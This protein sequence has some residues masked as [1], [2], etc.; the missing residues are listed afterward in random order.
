[1]ASQAFVVLMKT[2]R[3]WLVATNILPVGV[4]PGTAVTAMLH[5]TPLQIQDATASQAFVVLTKTVRCW[6]AAT[7]ILPVGVTAVTA[8]GTVTA[9]T[10]VTAMLHAAPLQIQDAMASQAFVV[11]M[12]T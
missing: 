7:N 5:A 6:L 1:M 3:C 12:K 2:V 10:E 8:V 9:V 11:L 4:T